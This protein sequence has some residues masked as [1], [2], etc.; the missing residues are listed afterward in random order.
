MNDDIIPQPTHS[1][2]IL[3]IFIHPETAVVQSRRQTRS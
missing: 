3:A 2:S 1:G